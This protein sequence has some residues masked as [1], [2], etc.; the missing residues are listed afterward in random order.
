[1]TAVTYLIVNAD[2]FGR[3]RGINQGVITAYERG[4]LTSASLMVRWPAAKPAAAYGRAHPGLTVGLHVDLGEWVFVEG[5]WL[6]LYEVVPLDDER[7]VAGE[8]SRQLVDFRRL[9][10]REPTHVDSHQHVHRREPVR[11]ILLGIARQLGVPLRGYNR[12]VRYSG[13]FYGQTAE[14]LPLP[15]VITVERL[16]AIMK[17]LPPGVTELG[18]HP[19][20]GDDL[21]TIYRRER[22]EE[23]MVLCDARI[24]AAIDSLGI[25]LRSFSAVAAPR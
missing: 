14:G 11:S 9:V 21:D 1:M 15:G 25:R 20:H 23:V 22:A 8:V 18:C 19:G 4:I 17:A 2:D 3:S 16:I 7:K 6:P 10:G 24:R 12:L 13:D 5:A